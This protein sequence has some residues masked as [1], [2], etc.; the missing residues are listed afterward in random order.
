MKALN[1][2]ATW[3]AAFFPVVRNEKLESVMVKTEKTI[4]WCSICFVCCVTARAD[5]WPQWL[6]PEQDSVWRETGIV[7]S[8][9]GGTLEAKWRTPVGVGYSGPAVFKGKVYLT[10]YLI[11][12]GKV[13]NQPY[14]EMKLDGKERV[15]CLNAKDGKTLWKHEYP[16]QYNVSY[17]AGPRCTPTVTDGK[18]YTMGTMGDL[19]C[20]DAESGE[21][22]WAVDLKQRYEAKT[23]LWGF[24]SHPVV[25]GNK[26]YCLAGGE[27]SVA[28][29]LDKDTGKEIWRSLSARLPGYCTPVLTTAGGKRQLIIFHAEAINGL[30]PETGSVYWSVPLDT[31]YG[32]S[33]ATPRISGDLLFAG[34]IKEAAAVL[35]LAKDAPQ[36]EVLWRGTIRSAVYC[37]NSTPFIENGVIFGVCRKGE[38]RGV[39]L[40]TGERLW[41]T[42]AA[43]SGSRWAYYATAFIVK[44]ED[45]FFLYNDQGE[46][47]IARLDAKGYE[48]LSR[49]KVLSPTQ[50][51]MGQGRSIVWSHPA[52]ANRCLYA[53]NN[54]ELVCVSLAAK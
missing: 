6:G 29:A 16:C 31:Y 26:L 24:A 42:Y 41:Q 3:P 49:A 22:I 53:R 33:I 5:D 18:V 19:R 13:S 39:D 36:A 23:P 44:H 11:A 34:G 43:T 48:E 9:P 32:C 4:A 28:I 20:L 37:V 10:D 45:R 50:P 46:L 27:G 21:L 17:P 8:L 25:D 47:I 35:Q 51:F 12:Q 40:H 14:Q 2:L 1:S 7:K 54:K 52:F 15:L 38:L 30:D